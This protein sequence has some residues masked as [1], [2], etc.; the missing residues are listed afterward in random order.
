MKHLVDYQSEIDINRRSELRKLFFS[1]EELTLQ[2][3]SFLNSL[4]RFIYLYQ[5]YFDIHHQSVIPHIL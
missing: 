2:K 1:D 3:F 5:F 4:R